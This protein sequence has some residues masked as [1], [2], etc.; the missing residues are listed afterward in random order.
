M[1][2]T[3]KQAISIAQKIYGKQDER[4]K[5]IED[6]YKNA[7]TNILDIT[8]AFIESDKKWSANASTADIA[9][10]LANLKKV[11]D[12]SS[13][14][15]QN[16]IRMAYADNH[17]KSNGD[18]MMGKV[19]QELVKANLYQKL[20]IATSVKG[21]PD[22][23]GANT[24]QKSLKIIRKS[25][26]TSNKS[27]DLIIQKTARNAVLDRH[28]DSG[29][30]ASINKQTLQTVRKI[31]EIAEKA[32]KSPKDSLNWKDEVSNVLTGGKRATNGQ[33]G[34]AAG[35]IRTATAQVMNRS[36]LEDYKKRKVKQYQ[37]VSLESPTTCADCDALDGQIFDVADAQEGVNYPLIHYNCQC[38]TVEVNDDDDWDT[39][40]H[41]I[42]DEFNKL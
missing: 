24:Y 20:Q 25:N 35:M 37:F 38:T 34:R 27:I 12:N 2:L 1:K 32:A 14:D 40:D 17:M 5:E 6:V 30:F 31:R 7:Q 9:V 16:F 23:I 11:Y 21:I 18:L 39:S 19:T 41:D 4:V 3:K 10:F 29:T 13:S 33:M 22:V 8:G 15:D 36:T 42:T 26:K 28:A